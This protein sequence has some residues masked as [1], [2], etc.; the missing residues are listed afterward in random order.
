VGQD[1]LFVGLDVHKE[2]IAVALAEGRRDG[3]V[4]F[5]GT[6]VN[7]LDAVQRLVAKRHERL[8][9]CYEAGPCGYAI[10]RQITKL[11][12]E[13]TVVAPSLTATVDA[14]RGAEPDQLQASPSR[15]LAPRATST[16][17]WEPTCLPLD[18]SIHFSARA[19][20]VCGRWF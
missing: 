2:K 13:C 4:R 17:D 20:A 10:Y 11:G 9:F 8:R 19:W 15:H 16:S 1:T 3:E 7:K 18:G 14:A 6:I 5:A 12:H